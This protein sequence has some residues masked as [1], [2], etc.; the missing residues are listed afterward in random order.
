MKQFARRAPALLTVV[1]VLV[2]CGV[3]LTN[4]P[5]RVAQQSG[6]TTTV[7]AGLSSPVF[8]A[9]RVFFL[10][11]GKFSA[12]E[13]Q[14]NASPTQPELAVQGALDLLREGVFNSEISQGYSSPVQA[15]DDVDFPVILNKG[16]AR[17]NL[18]SQLGALQQLPAQQLQLVIVQL[19]LTAL[20]GAPG[21]GSVVFEADGQQVELLINGTLRVAPFHVVD[22]NCFDESAECNLPVV[23]LPTQPS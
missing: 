8:P 11:G 16:E 6:T 23:V 15:I 19:A 21:V 1:S 14:G 12:L 2:G 18:S 4:S 3:P 5:V 7:V 9:V 20:L 10:R 17:I 22:F 13:R